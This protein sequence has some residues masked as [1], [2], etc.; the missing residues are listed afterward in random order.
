MSNLFKSL[1]SKG[2]MTISKDVREAA[3]INEGDI[4]IVTVDNSKLVFKKAKVVE[5]KK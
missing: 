5:V 3:N 1:Y 2:R 4:F